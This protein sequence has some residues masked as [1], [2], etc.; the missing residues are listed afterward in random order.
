MSLKDKIIFE[1][2]RSLSALLAF[3]VAV[4]V[5]LA[6][7]FDWSG[8]AVASVQ[9]I[10]GAFIALVG[11]FFVREAV[12]PNA[13]VNQKVHDTILAL[14]ALNPRP[15]VVVVHNVIPADDHDHPDPDA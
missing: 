15:E 6:F 12:T 5:G 2:V 10:W 4:I 8:E 3:G 7:N 14:D 1:P 9:A 13:S 11:T